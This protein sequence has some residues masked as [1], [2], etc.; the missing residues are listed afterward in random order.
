[1]EMDQHKFGNQLGNTRANTTNTA[2]ACCIC[3]LIHQLIESLGG[4]LVVLANVGN[5]FGNT[6]VYILAEGG[7]CE[8]TLDETVE[9]TSP[10][11]LH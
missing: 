7:A 2:R 5:T 6:P 4:V 11:L 8:P 9:R 3:A 1:M 10:L